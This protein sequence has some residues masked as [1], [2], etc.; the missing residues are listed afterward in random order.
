[1]NLNKIV[2]TPEQSQRLLDLEVQPGSALSF[3]FK[4]ETEYV[5]GPAHAKA[6]K[7]LPAWTKHELEVMLGPAM[8]KPD[9]E[10]KAPFHFRLLTKHGQTY[11][12]NGAEA[13]AAALIYLIEEGILKPKYVNGFRL[14][15][16]GF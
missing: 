11:Y 6:V 10:H 8:P 2:C 14:E 1:M 12:E 4:N 9:F 5:I 16:L 3:N 15:H 13:A 7:V